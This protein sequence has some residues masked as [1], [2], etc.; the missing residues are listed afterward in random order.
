MACVSTWNVIVG[1]TPVTR[2]VAEDYEDPESDLVEETGYVPVYAEMSPGRV[3]ESPDGEVY[4]CAET[5]YS[6]DDRYGC[7]ES[8]DPSDPILRYV[9]R[10]YHTVCLD[11]RFRVS[12]SV[13]KLNDDG[14]V[15]EWRD[16][17]HAVNCEPSFDAIVSALLD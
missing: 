16:A 8:T 15:G 17:D 12:Y 3:W 9:L 13:C 7:V 5:R 1:Y 4:T 10:E 6:R 14:T 2:W 11:G